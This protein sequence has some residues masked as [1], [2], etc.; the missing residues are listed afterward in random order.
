MD[1]ALEF[2]MPVSQL[3][4]SMKESEL[5][6]WEVYAGTYML[7]A[8]RMQVQLAQVAMLIV[9]TNGGGA[10]LTL[11]DYLFDPPDPIKPEENLAMAVQVF[12]FKPRK[13]KVVANG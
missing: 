10:E 5:R 2:G 8:R 6:R 3:M 12:D 4:K 13:K 9:K 7:P 11:K 1:L